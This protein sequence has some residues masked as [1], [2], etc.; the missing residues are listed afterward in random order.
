MHQSIAA[1]RKIFLQA[2]R[3]P[4]ATSEVHIAGAQIEYQLNKEPQVAARIF[5]DG[6]KK[7]NTDVNYLMKYMDFLDTM[8]D[9]NSIAVA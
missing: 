1:A 8:N 9:H 6:M 5:N 4:S 2:L 7:Y 3:S